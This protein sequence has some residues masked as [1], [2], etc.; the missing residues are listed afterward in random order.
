[1]R[2]YTILAGLA[3]AYAAVLSTLVAT[4][5]VGS[6]RET[7]IDTLNVQ[8][9]NV[10][11]PDGTLRLVVSN[12]AAF[13]GIII[14]GQE[15]PHDSRRDVAGLVFFNDEGTENGGLIFGGARKNGVVRSGGHLSFDQYEQDQVVSLEQ[16]EEGGQRAAGLGISDRPDRSMDFRALSRL[17][18]EPD[19]PARRAELARL[20]AAGAFG[21]PRLFL[22]KTDHNAVLSLRD[23]NGRKRLV[24]KVTAAGE[25]SIQFLDEA[26]KVV[27]T[28]TPQS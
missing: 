24:L 12:K 7:S 20:S 26:G 28:V 16:T 14:K 3:V 22:G 21:E 9:I 27:R 25:A 8:R 10:R 15:I 23:A 18:S 1:M 17:E 19:S 4:G 6:Q 11:E 5:A 13:P 2:A